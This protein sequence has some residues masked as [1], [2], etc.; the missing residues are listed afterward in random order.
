MY[1]QTP[2]LPLTS[3]KRERA[4]FEAHSYFHFPFAIFRLP[5]VISE[6]AGL[7]MANDK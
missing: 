2:Y 1:R 5:F 3:H 7:T 6:K 4:N